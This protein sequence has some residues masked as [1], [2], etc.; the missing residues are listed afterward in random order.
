MA[1]V[2]T[3]PRPKPATLVTGFE[4]ALG[5]SVAIEL[6]RAGQRVCVIRSGGGAADQG[7]AE[8][9]GHERLQHQGIATELSDAVAVQRAV[10]EAE[11]RLGQITGLV[12]VAVPLEAVPLEGVRDEFDARRFA[13]ALQRGAGA[14]LGLALGLLPELF[15]TQTGCLC[16]L[17]PAPLPGSSFAHAVPGSA[18][19]IGALLGAV[20]QVA[21][22][23]AGTPLRSLL[24]YGEGAVSAPLG[25]PALGVLVS[26][27]GLDTAPGRFENGSFASLSAPLMAGPIELLRAPAPSVATAPAAVRAAS[28]PAGDATR[29]PA[30]PDR[31]GERLAQ[32]FRATFGL[33]A[34]VDVQTCAIGTVPRWDSLGHLKLMME[35]ERALRVRLPAEALAKIQSYRDLERAVR[36]HLSGA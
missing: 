8:L 27:L 2:Q 21:D 23:C 33:S 32:T 20:R 9:P 36:A 31:I 14:F 11:A 3:A 13:E 15:A 30:G 17:T 19:L 24:L 1:D 25:A 26:Q 28:A 4:T 35:V 10:H 18:A 6:A 34:G 16:A 12:H 29:A 22:R 5:R 7:L